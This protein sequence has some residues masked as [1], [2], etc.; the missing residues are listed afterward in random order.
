M[1]LIEN[2]LGK[3]LSLLHDVVVRTAMRPFL[4][5]PQ[6]KKDIKDLEKSTREFEQEIKSF[7]K[8]YPDDDLCKYPQSQN[9]IK[10][11]KDRGEW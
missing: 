2:V 7:C 4:N 11:M 8:K 6:V 10:R 3:I 1:N 5:D 9:A